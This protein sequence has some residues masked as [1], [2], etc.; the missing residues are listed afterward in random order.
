VQKRFRYLHRYVSMYPRFDQIRKEL[1]PNVSFDRSLESL[2][3]T[4]KK[5]NARTPS[6]L[7]ARSESTCILSSSHTQ[8]LAILLSAF[9]FM[10]RAWL[11]IYSGAEAS[12]FKY[13]ESLFRSLGKNLPSSSVHA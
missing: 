12:A 1:A 13:D 2:G 10:L 8:G 5:A 11:E 9:C 3:Y 7:P 6:A 4:E